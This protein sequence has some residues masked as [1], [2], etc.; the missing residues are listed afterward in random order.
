[1]P[2]TYKLWGMKCLT[3]WRN[4]QRGALTWDESGKA[5]LPHVL[6]IQIFV[7]VVGKDE[8]LVFITKVL[9]SDH[10]SALT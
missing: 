3:T 7:G 2:E 6:V 1:M 8:Y 10:R 9:A 4:S 5:S